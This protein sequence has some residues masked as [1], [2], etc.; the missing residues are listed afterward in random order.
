MN[1]NTQLLQVIDKNLNSNAMKKF[2]PSTRPKKALSAYNMFYKL[3][4]EQILAGNGSQSLRLTPEQFIRIRQDHVTKPKRVHKKTHGKIG[5]LELNRLIASSWKVLPQSDKA[6]F[7]YY[8]Q[9]EKQDYTKKVK[10]WKREDMKKKKAIRKSDKS[11]RRTLQPATPQRDQSI[12]GASQSHAWVRHSSDDDDASGMVLS[13]Q[14]DR[15]F[16]LESLVA[17]VA[18]TAAATPARQRL[19]ENDCNNDDD[20]DASVQGNALSEDDMAA[21][22]SIPS[23]ADVTNLYIR[24]S[25]GPFSRS[26]MFDLLSP[27]SDHDMETIFD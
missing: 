13:F 6:I 10:S 20:D 18:A 12:E 26:T 2:T 16:Q 9:L 15:D 5:F 24:P 22:S 19:W 25:T 21:L 1:S 11:N 7:Y 8:A 4:R 23:I 14:V 17:P 3:K 27:L